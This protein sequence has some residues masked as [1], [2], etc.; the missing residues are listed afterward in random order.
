MTS[1]WDAETLLT[2]E[3]VYVPHV[4][5]PSVSPPPPISGAPLLSLTCYRL[6]ENIPNIRWV[7][8]AGVLGTIMGNEFCSSVCGRGSAGHRWSPMV[9]AGH[10]W[11][12]NP[13]F[14]PSF[15]RLDSSTAGLL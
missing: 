7:D 10:R 5:T 1:R 9:T 14:L 4:W 15:H 8:V 13:P 12:E 6:V 2:L 3:D 11:M